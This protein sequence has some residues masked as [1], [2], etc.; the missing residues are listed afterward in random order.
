MGRLQ[1]ELNA[2]RDA[3]SRGN[4]A[5]LMQESALSTAEITMQAMQEQM[6]IDRTTGMAPI[7]VLPG[8]PAG[9][10]AAG[11][12]IVVTG[13]RSDTLRAQLE[14]A[15][16]RWRDD[17]PEV[18]RLKADLDQAE[19][20]ERLQEGAALAAVKAAVAARTAESPKPTETVAQ[21]T[22]PNVPVPPPPP[23][24]L[25]ETPQM[26]Q[27]RERI[28]TLK[29]EIELT[30]RDI[31]KRKANE[32]HLLTSLADVQTRLEKLPLREQEMAVLM[33]DYGIS[34]DNYQRLLTNKLSAEM[35]KDM[36]LRQKSER[37]TVLDPATVPERPSKPN[38]PL[39]SAGISGVGALLG[40]AIAFLIELRRDVLL[41]DW[42]LPEDVVVL[43]TLPRLEGYARGGASSPTNKRPLF[44]KKAIVSS[45]VLGA[46]AIAA[47][48]LYLVRNR[49]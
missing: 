7:M 34:K 21:N 8:R 49:F 10:P 11:P 14:A 39:A 30:K 2:T 4:D 15:R 13:K 25:R 31:E 17:H 47:A 42:E 5:K 9:D 3:I 29:T 20:A 41:G 12:R 36:E 46:L 33:R 40:L 37:F 19:E 45:A 27:F 23:A 6:A 18:K 44:R 38:R 26:V 24:S 43:G 48:G 32:Q 22:A 16:V 35:S 1:G 28:Q